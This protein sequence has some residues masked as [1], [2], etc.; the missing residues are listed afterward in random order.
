[1]SQ[2]LMTDLIELARDPDPAARH[3]L[4][5]RITAICLESPHELS[6]QEK[7]VAGHVLIQLSREFET[8]LRVLL[9]HQLASSNRAPKTL[10]QVLAADEIEVSAPII[11]K[12][13]LLEERDLIDLI[14]HKTHAHR[15]C[16]AMRSGITAAVSSAL[17]NK[18]EADV[19]Q[20]LA[21]NQSAEIA[22]AAMEY[23]VAESENNK[24]LQGPLIARDDLP[25]K[26]AQKMCNFVSD[27]LKADILKK[28]D[29][30]PETIEEAMRQVRKTQSMIH[31]QGARGIEGKAAS[32][33]ARMRASGELS[34][35]R[36]IG[37][38]REQRL[39]LFLEGLAAITDLSVKTL[40]NLALEGE[41]QGMAV[42]CR[43]VG[44][45]RSQFAT[46]T[47]LLERARTG[48]A[49]PAARLQAVCQLFDTMP[50]D[51]ALA[52]VEQWRARDPSP[53]KSAA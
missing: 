16:V 18:E 21:Q 3:K 7:E 34:L 1:M 38:L 6:P 39:N 46:I 11:G 36:V 12:S 19:L 37:F 33:I 50:A 30:D 26:L 4:S 23:L 14:Q 22:S 17:V 52:I 5:Q 35:N 31:P 29:I 42:V 8:K 41:G 48:K 51:R 10:I 27:A 13:P 45:D 40:S 20:A 24:D 15:L 47:L 44:A 2:E 25:P 43:A 53:G 9:A 49:V 28:F 32:L